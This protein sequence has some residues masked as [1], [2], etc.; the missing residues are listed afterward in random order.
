MLIFPQCKSLLAVAIC[1]VHFSCFL[2]HIETKP[3][4]HTC[5]D[6][7]VW[8]SSRGSKTSAYSVLGRR[9]QNDGTKQ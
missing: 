4:I 2:H 9:S 3:F 7:N 5:A 8:L 1:M 6:E